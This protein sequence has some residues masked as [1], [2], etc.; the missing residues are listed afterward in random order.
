[1][2]TRAERYASAQTRARDFSL[3]HIPIFSS[4]SRSFRFFPF[5]LGWKNCHLQKPTPQLASATY[6]P[7]FRRVR[8][9]SKQLLS[10]RLPRGH[11]LAFSLHRYQVHPNPLVFC[12]FPYAI[13]PREADQ[14]APLPLIQNGRLRP[15]APRPHRQASTH[16]SAHGGAIIVYVDF[17]GGPGGP[18]KTLLILTP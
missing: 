17:P 11:F 13:P 8:R 10:E 6:K 14:C 9:E 12:K 2:A 16:L 1:M 5:A 3:L 15:F 7:S 18:P 4:G